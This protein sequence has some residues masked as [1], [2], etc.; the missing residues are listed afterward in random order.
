MRQV[1]ESEAGSVHFFV[2]R[3]SSP[4]VCLGSSPMH[5]RAPS[6]D[7]GVQ[8]FVWALVFFVLLYFGMVVL[9]IAKGT[10]FVVS[11]VAAFLIFLV[12]R[13]RGQRL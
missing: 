7:R 6:T 10:A 2:D 5:L 8:S 13:S 4:T 1:D 3:T 11:L 12:V 9:A